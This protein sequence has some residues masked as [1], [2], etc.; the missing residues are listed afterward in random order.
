MMK[1]FHNEGRPVCPSSHAP[2]GGECASPHRLHILVRLHAS[3]RRERDPPLL[4]RPTPPHGAHVTGSEV[5]QRVQRACATRR[6]AAGARAAPPPSLG[7]ERGGLFGGT[8]RGGAGLA[9]SL[10]LYKPNTSDDAVET[11]NLS[12]WAHC[13]TDADMRLAMQVCRETLVH[14]TLDGCDLLSPLTLASLVSVC[15]G[16]RTLSLRG[17]GSVN[18]DLA[19][20]LRGRT[21]ENLESLMLGGCSRLDDVLLRQA[22]ASFPMLRRLDLADCKRLVDVASM[23]A[24]AS[25]E[26]LSLAGCTSLHLE[27]LDGLLLSLRLLELLDLSRTHLDNAT[28]S[29]MLQRRT[30]L[31]QLPRPTLQLRH[32]LLEG[33]ALSSYSVIQIVGVTSGDLRTLHVTGTGGV[34]DAFVRSVVE[35]CPK[36]ESLRGANGGLLDLAA[37][38]RLH[39]LAL[40]GAAVVTAAEMHRLGSSLSRLESLDLHGADVDDSCVTAFAAGYRRGANIAGVARATQSSTYMRRNADAGLARSDSVLVWTPTFEQALEAPSSC[41]Y[42][43]IQP[44]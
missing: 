40:S 12:M 8:F 25:L 20:A 37:C 9:T 13:V 35:F 2:H 27:S 44:W 3:E 41:T 28:L 30:K 16:L 4:A 10:L 11:L 31:V 7:D 22:V 43:E 38:H 19:A 42:Y 33:C 15:R 26:A 36:V 34:N 32:L 24:L 17:C 14:L 29:G 18:A 23:Q 21:R 1:F 39:T 5:V 6:M